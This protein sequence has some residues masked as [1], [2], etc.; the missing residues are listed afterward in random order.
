MSDILIFMTYFIYYRLE[1]MDVI[2]GTSK[3][4]E[5]MNTKRFIVISLSCLCVAEI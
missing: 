5:V 2:Y 1:I 4:S 3:M